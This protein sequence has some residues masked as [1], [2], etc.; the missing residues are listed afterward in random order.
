MPQYTIA[1]YNLEWM[2]D[3]F[4]GNAVAPE[5]EAR[6]NAIA[7]VIQRIDPHVLAISEAANDV[8]EHLDFIA[9]FL[10]G[11]YTPVQGASRG[12]QNLVFYVRAPFEL[13]SIDQG[14]DF[15]A[16]WDIDIDSDGVKEHFQ[17]E[18]RPLE[19]VFRIGNGANAQR[20]RFILVHTKSKGIFDVVDLASYQNRALGN[21]KKLIAQA[22]RLRERLDAYL[23]EAD[24]LPT[25]VLGD[26]N[27]GPGLD[28]QERVLGA[29]FVETAMGSVFYPDRVFFNAL[30][31]VPAA[32][33]W[34]ADF[35]DP[36][37]SSPKGWNHRVWIDHILLGPQLM[38]GG[39]P[40]RFVPGSGA[41]DERDQA[42]R[43]A[44]DHL[45][46]HCLLSDD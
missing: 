1:A 25:I 21:R 22:T 38:A 3:M 45:A 13:V 40:L 41:I 29:S 24:P 30:R 19:A 32:D 10:N 44:S 7:T 36:I 9:R 2:N 16:P 31:D 46:I 27:D 35:P 12:A 18:R 20:V 26:M 17:W 6:A 15:Y 23:A 39:A 11:A 37:V 33:R 5:H 43:A 34:T 4:T 14:S 8:A 42:A 28:A